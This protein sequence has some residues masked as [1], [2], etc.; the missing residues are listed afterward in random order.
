MIYNTYFSNQEWSECNGDLTKLIATR[1]EL[2]D[3]YKIETFELVQ[4][5]HGIILAYSITC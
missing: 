3:E 2:T 5:A 4:D 1:H